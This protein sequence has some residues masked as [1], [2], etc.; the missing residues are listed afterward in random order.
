[1]SIKSFSDKKTENLWNDGKSKDYP[2]TIIK[3]ALK[4]LDTLDAAETLADLSNVPSNRFHA[5][6]G[7][8]LRGHHVIYVTQDEW[9]ISFV[10]E[11]GDAES[12]WL[13]NHYGD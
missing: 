9:R 4:K 7:G 1:M 6:K 2:S 5:I 8:K 12:V 10:W 13:S 3:R 11:N